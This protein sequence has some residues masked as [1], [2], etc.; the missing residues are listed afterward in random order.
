MKKPE[1][2]KAI[3]PSPK[4]MPKGWTHEDYHKFLRNAGYN[5]ACEEWEKYHN[6]V[7]MR[8]GI[9]G[10][11]LPSEE[12]IRKILTQTDCDIFLNHQVRATFDDLAKAIS[13]RIRGETCQVIV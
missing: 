13:K 9:L 4:T 5:Q 6:S 2:K 10:L 1:K 12:E 3:N 7:L 8:C 11:T